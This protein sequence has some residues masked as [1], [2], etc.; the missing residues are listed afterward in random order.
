[1]AIKFSQFNVAAST[2][3]IDYLVGYKSTDNVQI[4][5]SLVGT[6]TTYTVSTAQ[7]GAN[8]LINL[9]GSDAT[10][11]TITITA[12]T[13]IALTDNGSG[14]G[15]TISSTVVGDTYTLGTSTNGSSVDVNLDAAVG[16]D[17]TITLTPGT[18]MSITQAANVATI[19]NTAPG[20]TYSLNA[21]AKAGSSV[22]LNLDALT[23]TDS[24]VNL[25]EG[26]GI[27]LTRTS[28]TEIK[29]DA[30]VGALV[31]KNQFTGNGSTT[32]FSLTD[33]VGSSANINI[34]ISG[35]YQ[36]SLD[37]AGVANYTVAGTTL[38]FATAP[39][40]T[41]TNGIEVVITK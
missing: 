32:V 29:I 18:G 12:G 7:S 24:V 30:L 37:S 21:G 4:P 23:G 39:P 9:V 8:E 40:V 13:D 26:T 35:V 20:D 11:D 38:T 25:K 31:T 33:A 36:N 22:P 14:S 6:N 5:V 10:T 34:F 3:D 19:T 1:M 2:S 41:A 27:T 16:A 15:F 28:A 17:S